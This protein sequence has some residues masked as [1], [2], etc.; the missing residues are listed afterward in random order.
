[1]EIL[2]SLNPQQRK[3]VEQTEGALLVLAGA[4]S[5]KTRV[6]TLRIAYLIAEKGVAPYNILAVTFTNKAA[7][8]MRERVNA[9]LHGQQLQSAPL[10]STFH[11][12]C[13]RILRQ[14][15]EALQEGYTKSFTIYDTSDSQKVIKA[16][17]KDI[18]MD[19][20][21]LSARTVQS[22]ISSSKNRGEDFEMYASKV[23]YT[24]ERRAAIARVFKMY[25]E[26]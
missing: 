26:R 25:E 10:I 7:G 1:M 23:E 20:K 9:F 11:S 22:A 16:C 24:D 6:I 14:D 18:G 2:S 17:V 5:G 15:I 19:E 21:Q 8:E 12:L 4:G 3:A 13:V